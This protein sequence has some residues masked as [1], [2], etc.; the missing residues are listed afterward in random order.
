M[1]F[2]TP[3]ATTNYWGFMNISSLPALTDG[4]VIDVHSYGTTE[5]ISVNPRY[6]ANYIPWIGAGQVYNKPLTISEWNVQYPQV[7]RFTSP[8]YVAA[9]ASLQGWDAP[10]IYNYSQVPLDGGRYID[11]WST[12][13]D[14]A[15]TGLMPAAAIA[16]RLGHISPARENYCLML[17]R[18][19]FFDREL[20]PG[21][22]ATIRTLIER[23]KLTIGIPEVKELPWLTPTRPSSDFTIE[24]NP[25]RDLIPSG[26][27]YIQSDTGEI[28]RN[29][30]DGT[31]TINTSKSRAASGWIG[32]KSI[33]LSGI[34]I[35]VNSP[36]KA[37]VAVSSIDDAPLEKSGFMLITA[38]ARAEPSNPRSPNSLPFASEPVHAT[39]SVKSERSD[40][41]LLSLGSSGRVVRRVTPSKDAKGVNFTIPG[42]KGTHWFVLKS[43][44]ERR[45]ETSS[46]PPAD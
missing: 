18:K 1:G 24:T 16:Y 26:Q 41:Q 25:D 4:D 15:L 36:N 20:N 23:S 10:M 35:Y 28:V 32:G 27:N 45:S 38:I 33:K 14:P 2:H 29:W 34:T 37:V 8:L 22:S 12:F 3:I 40:L 19:N 39:I 43:G 21:T 31:Q 42:P 17:D 6:E 13:Y 11:R 5:A 44:S 9:I 30:Q 46:R 7:D